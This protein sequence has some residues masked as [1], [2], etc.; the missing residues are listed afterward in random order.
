MLS[1]DLFI[2]V[3]FLL[4]LPLHPSRS[5]WIVFLFFGLL[6]LLGLGI[7]RDYGV[8]TDEV[9]DHLN[10]MVN[11]KYIGQRLAPRLAQQQASY[12]SIPDLHNYIDNDHGVMFEIP[13]T[14]LSF[15]FTHHD[16]RAYY[17]MRHLL[18]FLTFVA[19]VWALFQ[20]GRVRFQHWCW[21][22]L[23]A[24]LLILSP[25]LFAEAFYN[26]KDVVF[27]A[28]F[29]IALY[30][31][32]RL[33]Q[34]PSLDRILLHSLASA[35]AVDIRVLGLLVVGFTLGFMGLQL[36][37]STLPLRAYFRIVG[38]YL[39]FTAAFVLIGWPYLWESPVGNLMAAFT[40]MSHFP[41]AG[42]NLYV[43]HYLR[44]YETPWHYIPVWILI[45]TPLPYTLAAIGGLSAWVITSVRRPSLAFTA[46]LDLLFASW[47]LVPLILV[48]GLHASVY[49]GW[50]HLYFIYP[51]LLLFAIRGAQTLYHLALRRRVWRKAIL[52]VALLAS[53]EVLHTAM[54]MVRM[55]PHQQVYF[56]FLP[57]PTAVAL[58]D[59]DY[60][61]LSY[62][63]GLEWILAHDASSHIVVSSPRVDLVYNNSLILPADQRR[64]LHIVY[65]DEAPTNYMLSHYA[66]HD[67]LADRRL[68]REIHTFYVEELPVLSIFRP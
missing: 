25:R 2:H 22:L 50:R 38:L 23:G 49:N 29:T 64:R 52:L 1:H 56:S 28:T 4:V 6:L 67:T 42:Q 31:L 30:T 5:W 48:V 55:H 68:G 60:W 59:R 14:V 18:V 43:G 46:Q 15:L 11:V 57:A 39:A 17:F 27:L 3:L 35:L 65:P 13:V 54:R 66:K 58:F 41:W 7:Y 37:H 21:G 45:T 8:S 12:A 26:G 47:L 16:S 61:G 9:V 62:R 40:R 51:A 44:G 33:T 34:Q 53:L 63:A 20:L 32:V 36:K 19:G 10:G 24:L